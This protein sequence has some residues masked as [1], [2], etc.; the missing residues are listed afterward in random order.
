MYVLHVADFL[1]EFISSRLIEQFGLDIY[2][3]CVVNIVQ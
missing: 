1:G 2:F 3:K